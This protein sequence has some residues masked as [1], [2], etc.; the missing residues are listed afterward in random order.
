MSLTE[1][2][3]YI[4][5]LIPGK[6]TESKQDEIVIDFD[7]NEVIYPRNEWYKIRQTYAMSIHKSQGKWVSCCHPA[8]TSAQQ[9]HAGTKFFI[10]TA[11]TGPRA[12]LI[13][14]GELQAFDYAVKQSEL[15][16]RPIWLSVSVI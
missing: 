16:A 1:T 4:T 6:Y 2:L 10:Y 14:L 3:G 13:L 15:P 12:K 9:A 5:D 8:I 11:I 7:G